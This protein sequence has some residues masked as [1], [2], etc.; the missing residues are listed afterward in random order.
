MRC[1]CAMMSPSD[2]TLI[3]GEGAVVDRADRDG[4]EREEEATKSDCCD[5]NCTSL[6]LTVVAFMA[7]ITK[8]WS[9]RENE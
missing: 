8:K 2:T 1:S 4:A 6:C 5:L 3:E 7:H 9:K